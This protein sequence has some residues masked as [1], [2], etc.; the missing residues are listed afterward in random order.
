MTARLRIRIGID[1]FGEIRQF[2]GSIPLPAIKSKC[3]DRGEKGLYT[4]RE[5]MGMGMR[6][7]KIGF[8]GAGNMAGAIIRGMA[9]GGFR[10]GD[11][12]VYDT[13]AA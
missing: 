7:M 11:I 9:A 10:G 13:D 2:I 1:P 5:S 4:E 8:I 12:L 6:T 3:I